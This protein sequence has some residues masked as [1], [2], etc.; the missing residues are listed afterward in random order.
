MNELNWTNKEGP[1]KVKAARNWEIIHILSSQTTSLIP[2]LKSNQQDQHLYHQ[3]DCP[4]YDQVPL[5]P[6]HSSTMYVLT[7]LLLLLFANEPLSTDNLLIIQFPN[8]NV[9]IT[10][11]DE[12]NDW[13]KKRAWRQ[14]Y[15]IHG[16][17]IFLK[18]Q[19]DW[20]YINNLI[21]F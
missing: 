4:L 2:L 17:L 10:W 7:E 18:N 8:S 15:W 5:R 12:S 3:I 19:Q 14:Q 13:R 1:T 16:R 11:W 21:F 9:Y 6:L 20:F